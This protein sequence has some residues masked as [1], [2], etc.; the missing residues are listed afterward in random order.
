MIPASGSEVIGRVVVGLVQEDDDTG[1]VGDAAE[2]GE[3]VPVGELP[4]VGELDDGADETKTEGAV[5]REGDIDGVGA[6]VPEA[7]QC[8]INCMRSCNNWRSS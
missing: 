8:S 5:E 7:T 4:F 1:V 2:V 6:P 3:L